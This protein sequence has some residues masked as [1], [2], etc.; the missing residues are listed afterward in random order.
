MGVHVKNDQLP[1]F[2]D[3]VGNMM[4]NLKISV[5]FHNKFWKSKKKVKWTQNGPW[6]N[7]PAAGLTK[8]YE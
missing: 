2:F 4:V 1:N 5:T 3:C 8:I 7:H 6:K